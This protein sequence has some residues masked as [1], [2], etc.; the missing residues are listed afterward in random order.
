LEKDNE[1]PFFSES[2][3]RVSFFVGLS[4]NIIFLILVSLSH[5][6]AIINGY[7]WKIWELSEL[8]LYGIEGKILFMLSI[9]IC[10]FS[11]LF[12][13]IVLGFYFNK[14]VHRVFYLIIAILSA[15][16][17]IGLGAVSEDVAYISHYVI[18][19]LFFLFVAVLV[20]YTSLYF[21]IFY[22]QKL[23][24]YSIM[25]IAVFVFN[26]FHIITREFFGKAY[27]QRIAVL[28]LIVYLMSISGRL[29]MKFDLINHE[30][31]TQE[32]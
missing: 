10:G 31:K 13:L 21:L 17:L 29:L 18:S 27:T 22:R 26:L 24:S 28:L 16:T 8:V 30:N 11:L 6:Y 7:D 12:P 25:G 4:G 9:I 3:F 32:Q 1:K 20:L 23:I 15:S 14:K 2:L 19:V 5:Y